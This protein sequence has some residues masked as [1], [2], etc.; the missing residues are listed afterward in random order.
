[1]EHDEEDKKKVES[2]NALEKYAYNMRNIIK[3]DMFLSK[4]DAADRKKIEDAI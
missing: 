3:D 2:K 4:L 1:M